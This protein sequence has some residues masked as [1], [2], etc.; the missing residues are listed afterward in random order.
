MEEIFDQKPYLQQKLF[1]FCFYICAPF[2]REI[3]GPLR[4]IKVRIKDFFENVLYYGYIQSS[5]L[6]SALENSN[7]FNPIYQ[8]FFFKSQKVAKLG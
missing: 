8:L 1:S 6:S 5:N 4:K 2:S 7:G 3:I